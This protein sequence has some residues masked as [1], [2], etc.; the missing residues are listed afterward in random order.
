MVVKVGALNRKLKS[1]TLGFGWVGNGKTRSICAPLAHSTRGR[2]PCCELEYLFLY[3]LP[4]AK[5]QFNLN[6]RAI[7]LSSCDPVT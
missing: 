2:A 4:F 1:Y 3:S 7:G 5:L 6:C